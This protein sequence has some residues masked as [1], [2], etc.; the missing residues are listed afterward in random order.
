MTS[1]IVISLQY[2]WFDN[3]HQVF[4]QTLAALKRLVL[5][6]HHRQAYR[7]GKVETEALINLSR[8]QRHVPLIPVQTRKS[9]SL[10]LTLLMYNP[11]A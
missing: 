5:L 10:S 8:R 3:F 6:G 9:C 7:C 2:L 1:W 11:L 4:A